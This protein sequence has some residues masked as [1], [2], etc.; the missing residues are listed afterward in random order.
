MTAKPEAELSGDALVAGFL[1][2]LVGE[3][4][5]SPNTRAG[6]LSDIAL[7]AR[8]IW[9]EVQPPHPWASVSEEA[10]R[11]FLAASAEAGAGAAT[12]KRRIAALRA[13]YRYLERRGCIGA[14][15]FAFLRGPKKA[16]AI[17][18]TLSVA[19]IESFLD[20]PRLAYR[21]RRLDR[22][23]YL[24]D[25][26]FFEFLY[27]TGCRISEAIAV[28]WRMI[29]WHDGRVVVT[30]KG[31]K[32]RLVILGAK[33][34]DALE[35][36]RAEMRAT[37]PDLADG[38]AFVF[39]GD[40]FRPAGRR[41]FERRM[42]RYLAEA[43]LPSDIS[44]HKLRHSFATHLLDAGA[45]LRCVQEMLGHTSLSTTQVYTHVSVERLKDVMARAHPRR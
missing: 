19:E 8:E 23:A 43:G 36:L 14:N 20:Q 16:K 1:D 12:L 4:N 3:R 45:D 40:A 5:A 2:Y 34:L 9:G 31:N 32:E 28:V 38:E 15:P 25:T 13:F 22:M 17:P 10:A 26:A 11:R 6:Y 27:S 35:K 18:R 33:A 24:R 30:G 29:G 39:L 7:F 37:R 41:F 21:A 42:K 44:P